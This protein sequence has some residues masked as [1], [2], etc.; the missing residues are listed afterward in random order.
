MS[1]AT[2][3]IKTPASQRRWL[4]ALWRRSPRAMGWAF[5][6]PI[7]AGLIFVG[8]AYLLARVLDGF[9]R[10][11]Q[12]LEQ[13][14]GGVVGIALLIVLRAV[15]LWSGQR[16]GSRAV[17]QIK[18]GLRRQLLAMM[19]AKGPTWTR[20][21]PSGALASVLVEQ[22]EALD[23]Y[24]RHFMPAMYA[25]GLLPVIFTL[26]VLPTDWIVALLFIISAPLIPL[27]MA[28]I[29][30]GAEAVNKKHQTVLSQLSGI[31]GDRIKGIFTLK[32]FGRTA[33]EVQAVRAVNDRLNQATM[34]VLRIAFISSAVLELF[35]ALGV[36][37][38]AVYVG[39]SFL[40]S[41][42]PAFDG[43][44]LQHGLFCLLIA[45]EVYQPLRQLAAGYHDRATAKAAVEQIE[46]LLGRL[47]ESGD[48]AQALQTVAAW[49]PTVAASN[50]PQP[51]L[52]QI[53]AGVLDAPAQAAQVLVLQGATTLQ[54]ARPAQP[55]LTDIDVQLPAGAQVALM[56]PSG[57]GKTSFLETLMGLRA[58]GAGDWRWGTDQ[59]VLIGQQPFLALGTV[60]TLLQLAD[61]QADEAQLW[62]ALGRA[63]A[64]DF[65]RQ[66]PQG[67]DTELGTRGFGLSGGQAHR[68]ALA[69]LFLTDP[70]LI[71]LDEP[72][73]HLDPATRDELMD[74]ILAF[75]AGRGLIVAT[76]DPAVAARLPQQWLIKNHQLHIDGH[77]SPIEGHQ[78]FT[79]RKGPHIERDQPPTEA[80]QCSGVRPDQAKHN[81][82]GES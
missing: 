35:A 38:V 64:E 7:L 39:F 1:N 67:L 33:A 32:L 54:T 30:W 13:L 21:N 53:S 25:A 40:G 77:P 12:P 74:E 22:V 37:G 44:T 28:L 58:P 29:G 3:T 76:H 81:K 4:A 31:F 47:P 70:A 18:Q 5:L 2:Q 52:L 51:W 50:E 66:L 46:E 78:S 80:N 71:L 69:R 19:L 62:S 55:L 61:P 42:G 20:Q 43:L 72:T 48:T 59:L 49:R 16:A 24:L 73:A 82:Q 10:L 34:S 27:F 17:E 60:R 41:F 68:L 11:Q 23:G 57:S 45:P 63:R 75:A 36:A 8:Q 79:G 9:I 15:C 6:A 26:V 65:V 14:A 56:G